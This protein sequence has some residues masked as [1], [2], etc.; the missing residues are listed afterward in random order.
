MLRSQLSSLKFLC[1]IVSLLTLVSQPAEQQ[2]GERERERER[3]R[4]YKWTKIKILARSKKFQP[5]V[6]IGTSFYKQLAVTNLQ[7]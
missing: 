3:E 2:D 5:T 7:L 6:H 1:T 4:A